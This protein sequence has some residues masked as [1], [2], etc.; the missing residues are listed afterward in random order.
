GLLFGKPAN[1][2]AAPNHGI[3]VLD[4][5]GARAGD[6]SSEGSASDAGKWKIDDIRVTKEVIEKRFNSFQRVGS[7]ELEKHY[8][9]PPYCIHHPSRSLR[10]QAMLLKIGRVRQMGREEK[11]VQPLSLNYKI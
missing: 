8:S 1:R 9:H 11:I 4:F 7:P 2:G 5:S 10:K 6:Q 3:V